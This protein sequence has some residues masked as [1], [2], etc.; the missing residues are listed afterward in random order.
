VQA[1]LIEQA[2]ISLSSAST[3][4]LQSFVAPL[5]HKRR[6]FSEGKALVSSSSINIS[7]TAAA[8]SSPDGSQP[9]QLPAALTVI[10]PSSSPLSCLKISSLDRLS[11]YLRL[12]DK[13]IGLPTAVVVRMQ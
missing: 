11:E 5:R 8:S 6:L 1:E 9:P 4:S 13:K 7:Q 10:N 3:S 12:N 2:I